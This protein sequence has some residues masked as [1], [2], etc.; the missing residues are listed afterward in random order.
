VKAQEKY[1]L[2]LLIVVLSILILLFWKVRMRDDGQRQQ[3]N[4]RQ[5]FPLIQQLQKS[6]KAEQYDAAILMAQKAEMLEHY[7]MSE[8]THYNCGLC[9]ERL[10]QLN[11]ARLEYQK[12]LHLQP[13][14]GNAEI[15][16]ADCLELLNRHSESVQWYN[17]FLCDHPD[18]PEAVRIRRLLPIIRNGQATAAR[19]N[20]D[21]TSPEYASCATKPPLWDLEGMPLKVFID[22]AHD[23]PGMKSGFI[24]IAKQSLNDWLTPLT[25]TLG[26]VETYSPNSADIII[27]WTSDRIKTPGAH[28]ELTDSFTNKSFKSKSGVKHLAKVKVVINIFDKDEHAVKQVCLHE[29]GHAIGISGHSPYFRDVMFHAAVEALPSHPT[30]RDLNTL[31]V[32][33]GLDKR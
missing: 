29:V 9:Y 32:L 7:P 4:Y 22:P 33:Y 5:A 11:S 16:L 23:V 31:R 17:K 8:K 6:F 18:A 1:S 2:V 15:G 12:A 20:V 14:Y 25:P 28:N 26:W 21:V 19:N 30:E 24:G 10:G 27:Q 3:E 13:K